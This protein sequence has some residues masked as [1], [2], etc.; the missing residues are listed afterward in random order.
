MESIWIYLAVSVW[1][2]VGSSLS[3]LARKRLGRGIAEYFIANRKVGGFISTMTY[4]ATTYSAFMMVGLVG[5]TYG[6]GVASLGFELTYLIGTA[7]LLVTF[8]PRFWLVGRKYGYITPAEMLSHRYESPLV[9]AAATVLSLVML[10]P[11]AAVQFMGAGYLMEG[12]SGG[13]ITFLTG[14]AIVA[15]IAFVYAWWAGMRSVAWTD[16]L[17]AT[18]MIAT[19]V[20]LVFFIIFTFFGGFSGFVAEME[21]AYPSYL[22]VKWD[23]TLFLGLSIPWFFFALTNPQASQR[24]F[25]PKNIRSM[26]NMIIGFMI[27]GFLYTVIVTILGLGARSIVP[28]LELADLAMPSL[29]GNIPLIPALIIFIGIVAAAISTLNSIILTLSSMSARDLYRA[30]NPKVSEN[31]ELLIGKTMIPI[32]IVICFVF[33]Q[34]KLG[35]IAI[36]SATASAGLLMQLPALLGVFCWRRGT[37]WGAFISM[38]VGGILVGGMFLAGWHPLGHWPGVWGIIVASV[39]FISVSLVTKPPSKANEFMNYVRDK[40]LEFKM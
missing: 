25:I 40:M 24:L 38:V 12:L 23:F 20:F 22:T 13:A 18:I 5:L 32:I 36:L 33:A 31:S 28:N 14:T 11:Y 8:A 3:Y 34:F 30:I 27:F 9:G 26:R 2:V 16:A 39:L 37:A 7:F 6:T 19:S 10:I 35:L 15:V 29:L 4:S 17:Q 1:F 21:T